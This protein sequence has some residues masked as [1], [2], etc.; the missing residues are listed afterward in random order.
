MAHFENAEQLLN[1][2]LE[3]Q[4]EYFN[5]YVCR[6]LSDYFNRRRS[7][8]PIDIID[9]NDEEYF[10]NRVERKFIL[11]LRSNLFFKLPKAVKRKWFYLLEWINRVVR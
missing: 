6:Q 5:S 1:E 10:L 11:I 4:G 3:M 9:K 2:K 8:L 7:K